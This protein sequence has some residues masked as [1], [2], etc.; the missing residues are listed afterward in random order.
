MFC[1]G[2]AIQNDPTF[3]R[4]LPFLQV[5]ARLCASPAYF[6]TFQEEATDRI[7]Q[8]NSSGESDSAVMIELSVVF[9]VPP[10]ASLSRLLLLSLVISG[11]Q[12][13]L[14]E[15]ACGLCWPRADQ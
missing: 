3:Q 7:S 13:V 11:C 1:S 10:F 6:S 8:L 9:F 14:S 2:A 5:C 4:F 15:Y 12:H